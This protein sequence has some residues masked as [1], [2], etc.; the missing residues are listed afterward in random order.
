M[1]FA[2][3]E[4][5][6][7][8]LINCELC[9][10]IVKFRKDVSLRHGRFEGEKFWSKPVTGFGPI[11]AKILILGLAPAATGGNRT[12]RIFTGDKTATFLVSSLYEAGMSNKNDSISKD[13][14]LV[15]WNTYLTA[16]LKCVPPGDKPL[17]EELIN[18]S[19]YL[20]FEID[21][22][23]NLKAVLV[24]GRIAFE[25]YVG[26]LKYKGYNVK[27]LK[28]GNGLFYDIGN[29]R[30]FSSYHPSPRNVNT[31]VL[32]RDDFIRTLLNIKEYVSQ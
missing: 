16:T 1:P 6:N 11:E 15:I 2:S 8:K 9:P 25:S 13:D 17:K 22:L 7:K 26:Y 19:R 20:Y 29:I 21:N 31:G 3:I 24:L 30:L 5:M 12:G 14:G 32:K 10:R 23:K 18:C 28:F 27:N 4:D